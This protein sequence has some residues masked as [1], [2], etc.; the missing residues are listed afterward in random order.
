MMVV[1]QGRSGGFLKVIANQRA[2]FIRTSA[3]RRVTD[4]LVLASLVRAERPVL[5]A[6]EPIPFHV[7]EQHRAHTQQPG[8]G[9]RRNELEMECPVALQPL[10]ATLN[11]LFACQRLPP[12]Q[13]VIARE[14]AYLPALVPMTDRLDH[15]ALLELAIEC[16]D[17]TKIDLLHRREPQ[18]A[19]ELRTEV[20]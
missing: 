11:A 17:V 14:D 13:A 9:A 16:G 19:P 3:K 12:G 8:R 2:G 15:R 20:N 4:E 1:F 10:G 5:L 6:H 18:A 7:I